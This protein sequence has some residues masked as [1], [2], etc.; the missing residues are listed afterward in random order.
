MSFPDRFPKQHRFTAPKE[1]AKIAPH[2]GRDSRLGAP[3]LKT[4]LYINGIPQGNPVVAGIQIIAGYTLRDTVKWGEV[5]A[6]PSKGGIFYLRVH[7]ANAI[8]QSNDEATEQVTL[9]HY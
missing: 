1:A 7:G 3:K 8:T 9:Q 6:T 2:F 5:K 4:Q